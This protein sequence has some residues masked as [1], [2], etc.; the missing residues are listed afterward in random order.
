MF[1]IGSDPEFFIS[2]DGGM[3]PYP[4]VGMLGGTKGKPLPVKG[5]PG[6]GMQEDN[7]MAEYN[8]PPTYDSGSFAETIVMG[9][10]LVLDRLTRNHPTV[11]LYSG[12]SAF[13]P[14]EHLTTPQAKTFGCSPDFY[15]YSQGAPLP[16]INPEV[17]SEPDGEWRFAGGHVHLGYKDSL[18]WAPPDFVVAA[19]CDLL[20]SIPMI[21]YG[22][23]TQGKRRQ[24]YGS[25]GRYRPTKYGIEYRSLSNAWTMHPR[26]ARN[27]GQATMNVFQTLLRG[28]KELRRIYND[29]PWHDIRAAIE[30]EQQSLA[31]QLRD[32]ILDSGIEVL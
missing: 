18:D 17:L 13:M 2:M 32:F 7:V 22:M 31:R 28:E 19:L 30:T 23:D 3:T 16:R 12:C 6:Y 15:A 29:M 11:T 26:H 27:V 5:R 4:I 25:P 21:G 20:I 10:A 8:V 24:F 1:S 14:H 9:R